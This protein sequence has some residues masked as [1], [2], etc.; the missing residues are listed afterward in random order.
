MD[1]TIAQNKVYNLILK[2]LTNQQIADKL[3]IS[4][5][6]VKVHVGRIFVK[7]NVKSRVELIVSKRG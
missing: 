3:G 2:G 6:T 7:N 4:V 5:N 1:L